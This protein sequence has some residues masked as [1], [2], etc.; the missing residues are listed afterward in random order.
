[1]AQEHSQKQIPPDKQIFESEIATY[2]LEDKI[3]ISLSK[4]VLRTVENISDNVALIKQITNNKPV[5][6]LIYLVNSPMPDKATRD[7]STKM[8]PEIYSAM[9]MVSEPGLASLIMKLLFKFQKPPIPIK[10]FTNT[11]QAKEWL[12]STNK[13]IFVR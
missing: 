13:N 12:N 6:L 10:H 3:L 8:L 2:W 1:M 4:S 11:V 7:F 5:P 9:A